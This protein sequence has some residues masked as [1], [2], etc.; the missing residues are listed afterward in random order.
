MAADIAGYSRMMD[1]DEDATMAAWRDVRTQVVDPTIGRFQGRIVKHTGDGFLAE[2]STVLRAVNCA[3][4]IQ[5]DLLRRNAGLPDARRLDFRIG[6]N[7]GDVMADETDIY[8]DGV[9]IAARLEAMADPGG[10]CISSD[11]YNQ[12]HKRVD[13]PMQDLGRCQVKKISTPVHVYRIV[14]DDSDTP[15][16]ANGN[17]APPVGRRWAYSLAAGVLA[18]AVAGTLWWQMRPP[19]PPEGRQTEVATASVPTIAVLPFDNMSGDAGQDYFSDG[20][21]EDLITDLSKVRGLAVIARSSTFAYKGKPTDIRTIGSELNARYVVEGSV[22][23]VGDQVRINVQLIDS[24]NGHHL[25]ADRYD[26]QLRDIFKL[27]DDIGRQIV[28]AL[29]LQLGPG[30]TPRQGRADTANMEAYDLFLRGREQFE[31]FSRHDTT[32]SRAFFERAIELDP[33]YAQAHALLA[34][35]YAFE[36]TN[37]WNQDD[38]APLRLA[39]EL[40]NRAIALDPNIPVAYFARGLVFREQREYVKALADAQKSTE[41]DPSYANGHVL[42][43]TLLYYAGRP[44]EGLRMVRRAQRLHPHHP[45]NYR[46]HEGQA[47][48]ILKRYDEAIAAFT[49]GLKQNNTS[50]RLR[51][52]LAATYAQIGRQDD[53]EWEAD[54]VLSTDPNFSLKRL[55]QAFPFTDRKE[56]DHIMGALRKAGFEGEIQ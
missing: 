49:K 48:F 16:I 15:S 31:R 10:I 41:I 34:W 33:D 17:K 9:N 43:A 50:Q 7:L 1:A 30:E 21:T 47:L 11:V 4:E 40:A 28:T 55:P 6:I 14:I 36:Y 23:R 13:Y 45:S 12:V 3:W 32:E 8:G 27:Q 44:E 24:D 18:L 39:T 53:A 46:F 37:G 25:W 38:E 29:A 5:R 42:L 20:L 35:T 51:V 2:F 56:L 22:R 54:M 26:G 52:W 19:S